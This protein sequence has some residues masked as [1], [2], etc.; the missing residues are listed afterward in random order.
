MMFDIFCRQETRTV[1]G[2]QIACYSLPVIWIFEVMLIIYS[3]N[4]NC[5]EKKSLSCKYHFCFLTIIFGVVIFFLEKDLLNNKKTGGMT[6]I[7]FVILKQHLKEIIYI[8]TG[9][10]IFHTPSL[11]FPPFL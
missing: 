1:T 11:F 5:N 3:L 7:L 9:I 4:F 8:S 10:S 2:H 6:N